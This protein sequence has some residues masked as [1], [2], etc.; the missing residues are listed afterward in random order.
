MKYIYV[1][2]SCIWSIG[3]TSPFAPKFDL[4]IAEFGQTRRP[5]DPERVVGSRSRHPPP[6]KIA[7]TSRQRIVGSSQRETLRLLGTGRE[8]EDDGIV[9]VGVVV[10]VTI[11]ARRGKRLSHLAGV[12]CFEDD[13]FLYELT[14]A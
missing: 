8:Q 2:P 14:S 10:A 9:Y 11:S 6:P 3:F 13:R 4:L 12:S 5:R 7:S 1:A